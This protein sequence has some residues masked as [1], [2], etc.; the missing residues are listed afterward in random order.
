MAA[1]TYQHRSNEGNSHTRGRQAKTHVWK[2]KKRL[3]QSQF[4][5]CIERDS[6]GLMATLW[7]E[8]WYVCVAAPPKG[9]PE[10]TRKRTP[11]TLRVIPSSK[12]RG[13]WHTRVNMGRLTYE[14]WCGNGRNSSGNCQFGEYIKR[15][16]SSIEGPST[17]ERLRQSVYEGKREKAHMEMKETAPAKVNS[18]ITCRETLV[19]L[20]LPYTWSHG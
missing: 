2:W 18:E 17:L 7:M 8:S 1:K 6:N 4:G 13:R 15:D 3:H 14:N 9:N 12:Q 16:S 11:S 19:A 20:W 5:S 10:T